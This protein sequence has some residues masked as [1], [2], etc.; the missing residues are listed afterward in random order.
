[1]GKYKGFVNLSVSAI[2]EPSPSSRTPQLIGISD[3]KENYA[4][5]KETLHGVNSEMDRIQREGI[6]IN[7]ELVG[8]SF[9]LCADYKF[10]LLVCG[11]KEANS[12]YACIFCEA[13]NCFYHKKGHKRRAK[14]AKGDIGVVRDYLFPAIPV[15]RIVI[16]ILHLF[17]RT[18]DKLLLLICREVA[19][20]SLLDFVEIVRGNI[21]CR[22]KIVLADGKVDF[23]NLDSNDRRKIL[24][25][26]ASST[27]LVDFL[28]SSR[29]P[30]IRLLIVKFLKVIETLASC[31]DPDVVK[32]ETST[33]SEMF[34]ANYQT[35]MV[36]PYLH[37]VLEHC[38]ELVAKIGCLNT[39]TQQHV[40]KLNHSATS[41]FFS[42][43]NFK[44]GKKQIMQQ[45]GRRLIL[46]NLE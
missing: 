4:N 2:D 23:R 39:F 43:T 19:D 14:I 16:D 15:D 29:G 31:D 30:R 40:E 25:F 35:S 33:F 27:C 12:R 45:H 34:L 46:S 6:E 26:F 36:T 21:V 3:Q 8:F 7:G 44:D 9:Y 10:L 13:A 38:H 20:E 24:N 42:V 1:M 18:S 5:L 17:L 32:L 37:M 28:G 41:A 22:G 11:F